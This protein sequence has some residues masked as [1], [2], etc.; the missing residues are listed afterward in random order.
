MLSRCRQPKPSV[1]CLVC[2][3][4]RPVSI[5]A[6]IPVLKLAAHGAQGGPR[7]EKT[8]TTPQPGELLTSARQTPEVATATVVRYAFLEF[9]LRRD[10]GQLADDSAS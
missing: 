6:R 1:D 4:R 2:L 8:R 5:V 3:S 7:F 10:L 9:L